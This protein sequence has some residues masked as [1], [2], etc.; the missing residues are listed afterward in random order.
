MPAKGR[1]S[2]SPSSRNRPAVQ[3]QLKHC[4]AAGTYHGL[5][6]EA[7]LRVNEGV[8]VAD[9]LGAAIQAPPD[10]HESAHG[11]KSQSGVHGQVG[12]QLRLLQPREPIRRRRATD[13]GGDGPAQ[14]ALELA[15]LAGILAMNLDAPVP[16]PPRGLPGGR[17][18]RA[19]PG[20]F[21]GSMRGTRRWRSHRAVSPIGGGHHA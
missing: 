13:C 11:P 7:T 14:V 2:H 20:L 4:D 1:T 10:G 3:R 12:L 5:V 15:E 8:G 16:G 21:V 18:A 6:Q 17:R 19:S 9:D